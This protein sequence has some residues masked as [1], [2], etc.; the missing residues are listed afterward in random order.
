MRVALRIDNEERAF[1]ADFVSA[2]ML[3]KTI[4]IAKTVN[5]E[6]ISAEELDS[7]VGYLVQLYGKQFT[8]DDVYDGVSSAALIPLLTQSIQEV[9][10]GLAD[11]TSGDGKNA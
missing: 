6:D 2:R 3:R 8:V 4:E 1:T 11:S 7:L 5:F 10:N 9:V